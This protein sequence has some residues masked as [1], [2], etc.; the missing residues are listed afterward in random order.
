MR[1]C[2]KIT[3]MQHYALAHIFQSSHLEPTS[4]E[5]EIKSVLE[6]PPVSVYCGF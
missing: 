5:S 3:V 1:A 2:E 6:G 4:V